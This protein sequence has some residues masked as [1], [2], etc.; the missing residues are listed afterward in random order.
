[1]MGRILSV[2][3]FFGLIANA[4]L[5]EQQITASSCQVEC[6][7]VSCCDRVGVKCAQGEGL[8]TEFSGYAP[9]EA[10]SASGEVNSASDKSQ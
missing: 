5:A 6:S 4:S 3:V 1:M 7:C 8:K 9:K 2:M 10:P